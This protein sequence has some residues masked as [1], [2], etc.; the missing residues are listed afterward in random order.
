MHRALQ[1]GGGGAIKAE[2]VCRLVLRGVRT[3][4]PLE[5]GGHHARRGGLVAH[6]LGRVQQGWG[7]HGN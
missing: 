7:L 4:A 2:G 3:C 5:E 6:P 1:G